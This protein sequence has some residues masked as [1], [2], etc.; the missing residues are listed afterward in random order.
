VGTSFF[1]SA[2]QANWGQTISV[3]AQISNKAQGNAPAT[4]AKIVLTPNGLTPGGLNDVTIGSIAVPALPAFQTTN[5]V[6]QVTLPAIPP[7]TLAGQGAYLISLIQDADNVASVAFTPQKMQGLGLDSAIIAITPGPQTQPMPTDR[8]DL[9]ASGIVLPGVPVYWGQNIQVST[10]VQNIGK[11]DAPPF[12]VRF[13]L[14]GVN[15]ATDHAIFLGDAIVSGLKANFSQSIIQN[16]QIP[17]RVPAGYSIGAIT[18]GRIIAIV[19]PENQVDET[20]KGNNESQSAPVTLQV[21]G[22][23]G[24]GMVPTSPAVRTNLPPAT[25]IAQ[26]KAKAKAK[27]APKVHRK[28]GAYHLPAPKKKDTGLLHLLSHYSDEVT[29]FF[30]RVTHHSKKK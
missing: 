13:V 1:V 20:V 4:R 2:N 14:T 10:S 27:P 19:D 7:A 6:Q 29:N 5:V 12:K 15:G 22:T 18:Y 23:N 8:P 26:A 21:F 9:A 17:S 3:T 28:A 24:S 30:N 16:L 11:A 25:Q